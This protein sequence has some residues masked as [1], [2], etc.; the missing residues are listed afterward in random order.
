MY[1]YLPLHPSDY[2]N[3]TSASQVGA[4]NLVP[5]VTD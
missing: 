4:L 1:A 2:N 5:N 3:A